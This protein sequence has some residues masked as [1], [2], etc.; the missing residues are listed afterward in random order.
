MVATDGNVSYFNIYLSN[1]PIGYD[2][3]NGL[4]V[5]WCADRSTVMPRNEQSQVKLF[6]SYAPLLPNLLRNKNWDKVNYIL[7]HKGNASKTDI[8]Y[9]F[10]HLIN[11]YPYDNISDTAKM[12]VDTAKDGYR[13]IQGEFIAILVLPT[14]PTAS[15]AKTG[16]FQRTFLEV[17]LPPQEGKSPGYWKNHI[18]WPENTTQTMTVH[19]V[20]SNASLYVSSTDT[21][22]D[23]LQYQGG[24][25]EAGAAQILLRAAV[26]GVL[27][28]RHP[29]INYPILESTIIE[30]VNKALGSHNRD[31]MLYLKNIIEEC[32]NLEADLTH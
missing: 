3:T 26:A 8:Q 31:T 23:A 6:N 1:V 11:K 27:N 17:R 12:L 32:N 14:P 5:G 16:P 29:C 25:S 2:V 9:A 18:N 13:P 30:E 10:W 4:Y 21:L 24:N 7:N 28:A 20:F 22:L 15:A 19:S